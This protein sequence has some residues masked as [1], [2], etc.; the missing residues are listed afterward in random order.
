VA[1]V[2]LGTTVNLIAPVFP[3]TDIDTVIRGGNGVAVAFDV[4]E[5]NIAG[6]VGIIC[7][8]IPII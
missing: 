2:D 6:A 5:L 4:A 3:I 7:P 8:N 1:E